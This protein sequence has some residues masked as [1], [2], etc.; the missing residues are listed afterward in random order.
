MTLSAGARLGPYQIVASIGAGGMGEVYRARDTS[1][2]RDVAV[3]ILPDV[4]AADPDRLARFTREAQTLAALNH[5][6]VAQI[7]GLVE[8]G[9]ATRAL[10]MELVE[11]EDL[12]Q[13]LTRG[14]FPIE[15][16][17]SIARQI[18]E[19]LEA[20]HEQSVIHR[21]LKPANVKLRLD[22]A[23]KVLD[24]GL[25]KALDAAPIST[26]ALSRSPTFTSPALVTGV[27]VL[28]GTAAYMSPEQARGRAADKRSDIWAFGCVLFEMLTRAIPSAPAGRACG[29]PH[30][31]AATACARASTSRPTV[32][33]PWSSRGGRWNRSKVRC[34]R[35]SC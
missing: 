13:R 10:V 9:G 7:Y 12:S 33:V 28:L 6:N 30:R 8:T 19:A 22:G 4:F 35:R 26:D 14:A 32:N 31:S 18:A 15:E 2:N 29:R 23:V 24:F 3:K 11:G 27:G 34:T 17:L 1:L 5:P 25:A 20:A 16:G 21:D